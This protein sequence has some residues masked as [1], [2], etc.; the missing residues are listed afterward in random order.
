[1]GEGPCLVGSG[2][3]KKEV[4]DLPPFSGVDLRIPGKVFIQAG[5]Q[6]VTLETFQNISQEIKMEVVGSTLV[7]NA[8]NCLEYMDEEAK[9]YVYLP[10]VENVELKS[11]GQIYVQ[12]VPSLGK[13]RLSLSG[14]GYLDYSGNPEE[15]FVLHSGSGDVDLFGSAAYLETTLSGS[16]RLRGFPLAAESAKTTL[17]GSGYQQ[18]WVKDRLDAIITG[19]GN[20]YYRGQP[21]LLTV[22][23]TSSGKVINSNY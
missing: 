4:R 15:L 22:Y 21:Q 18:V 13:L 7:I 2:A 5:P 12:S 23:T 1:M 9:I 19:S 16:G 8:A 20:I 3:V 11:S 14:S 10:N 6:R 17:T